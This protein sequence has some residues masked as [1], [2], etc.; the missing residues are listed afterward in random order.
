MLSVLNVEKKKTGEES[1]N[2][3]LDGGGV[4]GYFISLPIWWPM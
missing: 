4:H 1:C 3:G 2:C